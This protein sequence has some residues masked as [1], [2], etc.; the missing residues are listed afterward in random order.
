MPRLYPDLWTPRLGYLLADLAAIIAAVL[1]VMLGLWVYHLVDALRIIGDGVITTGM[2][3]GDVTSHVQ[4]TLDSYHFPRI[5][6]FGGEK[7][8]GIGPIPGIH[9]PSYGPFGGGGL[10]TKGLLSPV[11]SIARNVVSQ[12]RDDL[13]A[14]DDLALVLGVSVG[15][16]PLVMLLLRFIPW[17]IRKTRGLRSLDRLLHTPGSHDAS[18]SLELLAARALYTLPF[19]ELLRY[20][21][22]PIA[23][24]R[25]GRHYD[26][27]KA[28]M[29]GEGLDVKRYLRRVERYSEPTLPYVPH[30]QEEIFREE[31]VV[32]SEHIQ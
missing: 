14:V 20:S 31:I 19:D 6:P 32:E 9:L 10:P 15:G 1:F 22:D 8:P 29:A 16:L 18:A 30:I 27:A 28:T 24:W 23:E 3:L 25:E 26:L 21:K 13:R 4:N 2:K 17:R 12:G 5:G 7:I 11:N